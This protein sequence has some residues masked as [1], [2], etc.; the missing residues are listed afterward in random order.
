MQISRTWATPLTIG[1]FVVMAVTGLLLFFHLD[2]S[3]SKLAHEWLGWAFVLGVA[4]HAWTNRASFKAH[5][6]STRGRVIIGLFVVLVVVSVL[7]ID[8]GGEGGGGG[9][10][11]GGMRAAE[12]ALTHAPLASVAPLAD[13]D[14]DAIVASLRAAGFADASADRS[15]DDLVGD[16]HGRQEQAVGVV[17]ATE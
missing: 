15:I 17:F 10:G 13:R 5:L 4:L 11:G 3:L 6:A 2:T 1:V 16:D 9:G 12:Y 8:G 7:P 14:V